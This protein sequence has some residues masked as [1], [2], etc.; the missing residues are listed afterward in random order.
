MKSITPE[1][2]GKLIRKKPI[3]KSLRNGFAANGWTEHLS[4]VYEGRRLCL[5][6]IPEPTN[7]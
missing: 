6:I 7:H 4:A 1:A 2:C 3:A 5:R